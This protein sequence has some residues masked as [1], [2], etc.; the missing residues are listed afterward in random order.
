[1]NIKLQLPVA[2]A[3]RGGRLFRF[4]PATICHPERALRDECLPHTGN[5]TDC[6]PERAFRAKDLNRPARQT[7]TANFSPS[8][9]LNN[10]HPERAF[11]AKDLTQPVRQVHSAN[12]APSVI[13]SLL[14]AIPQPLQNLPGEFPCPH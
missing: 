14:S 9:N 7:R 3:F 5:Q 8:A 2:A 1:M 6:H 10:C 11:R 13:C 4:S 12:L